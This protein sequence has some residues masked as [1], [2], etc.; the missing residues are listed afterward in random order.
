M[1]HL[2]A[3]AVA[4]RAARRRPNRPSPDAGPAQA[5]AAAPF[6]RRIGAYGAWRALRSQGDAR[7]TAGSSLFACI[8]AFPC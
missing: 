1:R 6:A 8:G 7:T 4:S 5:P 3:A 2:L